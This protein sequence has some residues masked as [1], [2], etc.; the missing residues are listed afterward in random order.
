MSNF[1]SHT[2]ISARVAQLLQTLGVKPI[3]M[4]RT[5]GVSKGYMSLLLSGKTKI[6]YD[7]IAALHA[8]YDV[9]ANWLISG[10]GEMF[11]KVNNVSVHE[12]LQ[13]YTRNDNE[14]LI[15]RA[16]LEECR[17]TVSRLAGNVHTASV[18][19]K[20]IEV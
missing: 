6:G 12:P 13:T 8:V 7:F 10:N 15:L 5:C 20:K 1:F 19:T 3:E 4:A 17:E 9:N 11:N 2:E 16:K 14:V 18:L